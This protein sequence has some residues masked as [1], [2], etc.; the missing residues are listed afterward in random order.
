M[1][2]L[3]FRRRPERGAQSG[4]FTTKE[5]GKG[6]GLG[7]ATVFNIARQHNGWVEVLSQPG[8]GSTFIIYLPAITQ[9]LPPTRSAAPPTVSPIAR[10]NERI[11]IVE[12]EEM[13][14]ELA[15]EILRDSGYQILEAASGREAL[16]V[17]QRHEGKIDLLLT[18]MVMPEG[19]SGVELAER[20][21]AETPQLKVIFMSGYT[22]DD[23]SA[24]LLARTNASFIQK[25]YGHAELTQIVRDCLDRKTG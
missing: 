10:G 21:V 6:T 9:S 14:R 13:L 3:R 18:D 23:V 16:A 1:G 2:I 25:P 15:R 11:L 24:E 4:D 5:V 20:L 22:S 17:W 12:D 7:L 8:C 19:V